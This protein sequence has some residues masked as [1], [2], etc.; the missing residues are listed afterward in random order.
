MIGN[1]SPAANNFDLSKIQG[2]SPRS[3]ALKL[4]PASHPAKVA[5]E[6]DRGITKKSHD[7]VLAG[8]RFI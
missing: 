3:Q 7:S 4:F 2:V 6:L 8:F 1:I 5:G